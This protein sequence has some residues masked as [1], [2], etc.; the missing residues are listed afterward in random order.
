MLKTSSERDQPRKIRDFFFAKK[1]GHQ[2]WGR[3]LPKYY[4]DSSIKKPPKNK[5]KGDQKQDFFSPAEK[6]NIRMP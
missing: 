1:E 5:W 2:V 4:E 3:H 6:K